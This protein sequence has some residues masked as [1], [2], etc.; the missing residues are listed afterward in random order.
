MVA[1]PGELHAIDAAVPA[2]MQVHGVHC[3]QAHVIVEI[4]C[5]VIRFAGDVLGSESVAVSALEMH[6]GVIAGLNES[7]TW[8]GRDV[9]RGG[10]RHERERR[11]SDRGPVQEQVADRGAGLL[12]EDPL[13]P[14]TQ[15]R[16]C[17]LRWRGAAQHRVVVPVD[18]EPRPTEAVALQ[19]PLDGVEVPGDCRKAVEVA[20]TVLG[21]SLRMP[22]A[23][24]RIVG[25]ADPFPRVGVAA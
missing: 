1:Q 12:A 8:I 6:C 19:G 22:V 23:V 2:T 14:D 13:I 5:P 7:P 10:V 11:R 9:D 20:G 16:G 3:D 25:T 4:V 21:T 24:V 18:R 15:G 17:R